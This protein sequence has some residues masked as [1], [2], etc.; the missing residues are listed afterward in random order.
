[1]DNLFQQYFRCP[2]DYGHLQL[3]GAL[4]RSPGFFQFG[5]NV[6]CFGKSSRAVQPGF[7][8]PELCDLSGE[9]EIGPSLIPLPFDLDEDEVASCLRLETYA[10][11]MH[12]QGARLGARH[13][14]YP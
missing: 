5:P 9:M 11:Q 10:G 1:M 8:K 14:A 2:T 6:V 4:S 13:P 3:K 12:D 7:C